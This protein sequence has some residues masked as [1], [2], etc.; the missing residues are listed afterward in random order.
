MPTLSFTHAEGVILLRALQAHDV[1]LRE[2]VA[3]AM[4]RELLVIRKTDS[5]TR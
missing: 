4:R 3:E 1:Q 2:R 5:P